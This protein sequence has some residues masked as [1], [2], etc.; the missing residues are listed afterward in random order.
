M[1]INNHYLKN[2]YN[3]GFFRVE[4]WPHNNI[5]HV[6]DM[7]ESS[8]IN[9]AGGGVCEIGVHHGKL[10][11]ALNCLVDKKTEPSFAIDV[12]ED[13][14]LNID[15]SGKGSVEIFKEN[16]K[17]LDKF[18][19]E[20]TKIIKGDSTDSSVDLVKQIGL[21]TMRYVSIDGG[22]TAE[23][24]INDLQIANQIV[25]NDGVVL[26]DDMC[27]PSWVGVTEGA[28]KY[29][30]QTPTLVPFSIACDKLWLCK[31]SYYKKYFDFVCNSDIYKRKPWVTKFVGHEVAVLHY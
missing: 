9:S 6:V 21:G 2:Y 20:N 18:F 23:H 31:L 16:L 1:E 24:T 10:Y 27:H 12:F 13:Q 11:I 29:L 17:N 4:G 25:K 30:M 14:H 8:G 22:H 19:G 15:K 26:L 3:N 5:P 28:V 7:L